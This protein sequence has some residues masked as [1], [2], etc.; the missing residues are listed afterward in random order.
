MDTTEASPFFTAE[1]PIT[2]RR[3]MAK[4]WLSAL[5]LE[6]LI[7]RQPKDNL[8]EQLWPP[9]NLLTEDLVDIGADAFFSFP[10]ELRDLLVIETADEVVLCPTCLSK[11]VYLPDDDE[12][13]AA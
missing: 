12:E 2:I 1:L 7:S 11:A 8:P 10:D 9:Q 6:L 13:G 3:I 4:T 5:A